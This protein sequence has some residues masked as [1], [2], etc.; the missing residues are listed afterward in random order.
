MGVG[1]RIEIAIAAG[2]LKRECS[3]CHSD[4]SVYCACRSAAA[5]DSVDRDNCRLSVVGLA[6]GLPLSAAVIRVIVLQMNQ[7]TEN[8]PAI[9]SVIAVIVLTVASLAT[10]LPARKA[11]GVDAITA[12]RA[13]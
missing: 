12:L 2:A 13:D 10:W 11:A 1:R 5:P 7:T 4:D 9:V 8:I 3:R 6:I